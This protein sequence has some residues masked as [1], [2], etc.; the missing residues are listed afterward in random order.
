MRNHTSSVVPDRTLF[1]FS[2]PN[3]PTSKFNQ[4]GLKSSTT[5]LLSPSVSSPSMKLSLSTKNPTRHTQEFTIKAISPTLYDDP[6]FS[7][8]P[9]VHPFF[10]KSHDGWTAPPMVG[11]PT[12]RK[13]AHRLPHLAIPPDTRDSGEFRL[14]QP[15][16]SP[17][18]AVEPPT[19]PSPQDS[20]SP[21]PTNHL[22]TSK[23]TVATVTTRSRSVPSSTQSQSHSISQHSV[24]APRSNEK[25]RL[26][27]EKSEKKRNPLAM[28][29]RKSPPDSPTRGL[30][31]SKSKHT[32][33]PPPPPYE[34]IFS[35]PP[36]SLPFASLEIKTQSSTDVSLHSSQSTMVSADSQSPPTSLRP[37]GGKRRNRKNKLDRIDELDETNPLGIPVHHGGPYE[38]IQRLVQPQGRRNDPYNVGSNYQVKRLDIC[39]FKLLL[40]LWV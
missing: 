32:N 27:V 28:F 39:P 2:R 11:H 26:P 23:D 6:A 40:T 29:W 35:D 15:P 30:P 7:P 8:D 14:I 17:M 20:P 12:L 38:A 9:H 18:S 13:D 24:F 10:A 34:T 19:K 1:S 31:D 3:V 36:S 33:E 5:L 22:D 4:V 37:P 16:N 25:S 21:S